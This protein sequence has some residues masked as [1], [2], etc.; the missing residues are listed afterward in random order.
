ME[1]CNFECAHQQHG[2]CNFNVCECEPEGCVLYEECTACT[3][4]MLC[5]E[6]KESEL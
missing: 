1:G 6:V 3:N 5:D 2:V 4:L